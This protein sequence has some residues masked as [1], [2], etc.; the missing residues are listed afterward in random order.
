MGVL[1]RMVLNLLMRWQILLYQSL[2][3]TGNSYG[4]GN[5]AMCGKAYDP[6]LLLVGPA[7]LAVMGGSQA[8]V[9]LQIDFFLKAKERKFL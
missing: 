1:L 8:K 3:I 6:D 4:A 9:L 7:E 5:Y 2:P